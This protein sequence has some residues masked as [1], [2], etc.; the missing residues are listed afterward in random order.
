VQP[1]FAPPRPAD[2]PL[3][4]LS[5]QS[6]VTYGHVGNAAAVFPLQRL[7]FEVWPLHT[8]LLSNH[9]GYSPVNG[10]A[11]RGE[12]FAP[13]VI[14]SV[15]QALDERAL[16]GHLSGVLSG[17]LGKG[18]LG[19]ALA[20]AVG[21]ARL[22]AQGHPVLYLCDPVLGD[23]GSDGVGRV[24]TSPEIAEIITH[25]LLPLADVITPNRFELSLLSNQTVT[26]Q[27]SAL[28]AAR[29][30]LRRPGHDGPSLVIVTSMP[31]PN[32]P[33][34]ISCLAITHDGAWQVVTP[35]LAFSTPL[36][37][38]GDCLAAMVIGFLLKGDPAPQALAHAV[39]ALY[40][41]LLR[42]LTVDPGPSGSPE[43]ALIAAQ[44]QIE[45]PDHLFEVSAIG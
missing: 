5:L 13:E 19:E 23:E 20:Q 14:S 45:Q 9:A 39:S 3:N 40:A 10:A 30:L 11:T 7:G 33:E 44:G 24:Y 38:T 22:A 37:G 12:V 31:L 8:C 25:R 21:K 26:D 4:I 34:S 36:S 42:T 15:V 18:S 41:I 6:H 43:L 35:R 28:S 29:R 2:G 16:L 27:A 32:A 1:T 17:W